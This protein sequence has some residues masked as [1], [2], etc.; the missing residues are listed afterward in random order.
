MTNK[1]RKVTSSNPE[2][3]R[4][5]VAKLIANFEAE[6]QSGELR[7]KVLALI[8]IFHGLRDIGKALI[9]AEYASA[10]RDRICIT[11]GSILRLLSTATSCLSSQGFRSTHGA[12]ANYV[13]SSVG[14]L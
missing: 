7:P 12:C 8:P 4:Q 9:P 10:A 11:S 5:K 1:R 2:A 13:C 6:L 14:Q 3:V